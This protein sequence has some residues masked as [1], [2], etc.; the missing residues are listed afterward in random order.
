MDTITVKL[1]GRNIEINKALWG[2]ANIRLKLYDDDELGLIV[3]KYF[4]PKI[5]DNIDD[6]MA[7]Y[8]GRQIKQ[9]TEKILRE[10]LNKLK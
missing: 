6:M 9:T 8:S 7:C 3:A 4:N 5:K 2:E 10:E 1:F